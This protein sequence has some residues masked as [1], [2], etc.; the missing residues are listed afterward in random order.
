MNNY[1]ERTGRALNVLWAQY[2]SCRYIANSKT[3]EVRRLAMKLKT[4]ALIKHDRIMR[5]AP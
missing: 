2:N 4:K 1:I 5:G 3:G